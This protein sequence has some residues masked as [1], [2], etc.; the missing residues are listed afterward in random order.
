MTGAHQPVV[1]TYQRALDEFRRAGEASPLLKRMSELI[2]LLDLTTTLNSGLS[3]DDILDAALLV[4]MGEMQATR[5]CLLV[6]GEGGAYDVVASRG[7]DPGVPRR[8]PAPEA[9]LPGLGFDVVCPSL[10]GYGFSGKPRGTGWSID[11]IAVA[12]ETLMGRLGYD[13]Y[14]AQGGDWARRSPRRSAAMAA[15]AR[16][17]T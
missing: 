8:M 16:A 12:W 3:R 11:K 4:V 15:A 2:S 5:G 10:P 17:F 13:R 9:A 14:G 7:L 1:L 6:R